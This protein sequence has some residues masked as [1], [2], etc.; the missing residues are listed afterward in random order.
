MKHNIFAYGFID[1]NDDKQMDLKG[2]CG[3]GANICRGNHSQSGN[4]GTGADM[5]TIFRKSQT[6]N[7]YLFDYYNTTTSI[8]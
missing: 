6:C 2:R 7:G 8:D 1:D 3:T 5:K 4:Y